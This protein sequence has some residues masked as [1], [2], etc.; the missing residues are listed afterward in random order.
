MDAGHLYARL[1]IFYCLMRLWWRRRLRWRHHLPKF[2]FQ[3]IPLSIERPRDDR[4]NKFASD[5][6]L[7]M[8]MNVGVLLL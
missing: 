4:P 8:M 7:L 1:N 3:S 2:W 6:A 5:V